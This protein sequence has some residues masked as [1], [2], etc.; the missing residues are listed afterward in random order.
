MGSAA[1]DRPIAVSRPSESKAMMEARQSSAAPIA[2]I[3]GAVGKG[4]LR[5]RSTPMAFMTST[6]P[7]SGV[8]TISGGVWSG[9]VSLKC[10]ELY[11]R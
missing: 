5:T 9:K 4:K 3:S 2:S 11:R 7:S 8:L 10:A 6:T 1:I